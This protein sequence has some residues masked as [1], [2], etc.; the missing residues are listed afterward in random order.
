MSKLVLTVIFSLSLVGQSVHAVT[1]L[2]TCKVTKLNKQVMESFGDDVKL[3]EFNPFVDHIQPEAFVKVLKT[4]GK[5]SLQLGERVY[6]NAKRHDVPADNQI[7]YT[8]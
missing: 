3:I 7:A 4:G 5:L 2:Y 1:T 6:R 8:V